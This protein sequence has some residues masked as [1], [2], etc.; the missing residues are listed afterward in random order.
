MVPVDYNEVSVV[1]G[2]SFG[3]SYAVYEFCGDWYTRCVTV[4]KFAAWCEDEGFDD[5]AEFE[6][7]TGVEAEEIVGKW[8]IVLHNRVFVGSENALP[9]G[10]LQ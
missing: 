9:T 4:E 5:V 8:F 10:H 6:R 3:K 2:H 7:S 1:H